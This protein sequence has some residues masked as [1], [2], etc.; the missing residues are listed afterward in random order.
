MKTE[1]TAQQAEI[2]SEALSRLKKLIHYADGEMKSATFEHINNQLLHSQ[3]D[4]IEPGTFMS[5][6]VNRMKGTIA[7]KILR[8]AIRPVLILREYVPGEREKSLKTLRAVVVSLEEMRHL[9]TGRKPDA[10][11]TQEKN[12]G[13]NFRPWDANCQRMAKAYTRKCVQDGSEID[14]L[15]FIKE[16]LRKNATKYPDAKAASTIDRAFRE[17]ESAWK[18]LLTK[19]LAERTQ[20]GRKK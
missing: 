13:K 19:A 12:S 4:G 11:R 10:D 7:A 9:E 15:P 14:R 2:I 3:P 8:D 20:T 18:P 6:A 5:Q 16:E 17:N 1:L